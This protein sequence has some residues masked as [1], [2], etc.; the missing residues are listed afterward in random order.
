MIIL[1]YS[2]TIK[3]GRSYVSAQL[4]KNGQDEFRGK[5][6]NKWMNEFHEDIHIPYA[7]WESNNE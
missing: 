2:W 4:D 7:I 6:K 3:A 1:V 5:L